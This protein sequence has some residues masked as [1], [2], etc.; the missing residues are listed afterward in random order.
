[1]NEAVGAHIKAHSLGGK[2]EVDNLAVVRK[3]H[4]TAMGEMNASQYKELYMA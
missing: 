1:M 2:T 4:N 3:A